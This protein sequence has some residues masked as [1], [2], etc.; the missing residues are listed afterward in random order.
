MKFPYFDSD[1]SAG[2]DWADYGPTV[3]AGILRATLGEFLGSG[4]S[5]DVYASRCSPD[6]VIKVEAKCGTF[7]NVLEWEVWR[8]VKHHE[9]AKWFA[10]CLGIDPMGIT[11]VM[12]RTKPLTDRQWNKA[13]EL[14][15]FFNDLKQDNFGWLNGQ[16]VCHD[17][18]LNKLMDH[19]VCGKKLQKNYGAVT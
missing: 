11:L 17:Y 18:S 2:T 3:Q 19:G 9:N 7:H 4:C 15:W 5:R 10:P 6:V 12:S 14:P 8:S 16:I 13:K 1:G